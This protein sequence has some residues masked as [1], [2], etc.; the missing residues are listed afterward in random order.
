MKF[1]EF[2]RRREEY[3]RYVA[4]NRREIIKFKQAIADFEFNVDFPMFGLLE[5]DIE[6]MKVK[7]RAFIKH[8]EDFCREF[9]VEDFE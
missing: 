7:I 5:E 6:N 1:E 3:K 2:M 4:M 8:P 9:D